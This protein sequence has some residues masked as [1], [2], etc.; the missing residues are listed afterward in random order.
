MSEEF[1]EKLRRYSEGTLSGPELEEME[2]ELAKMEEYQQFLEE[3]LERQEQEDR[4]SDEG[5][6]T[7]K[8]GEPEGDHQEHLSG[9]RRRFTGFGFG[10]KRNRRSPKAVNEKAVIRSGKWRA[11]LS[12]TLTVIS[13]FL[14]LFVLS[15]IVTAVYYDGTGK[16]MK[17]AAVAESAVALSNPNVTLDLN[18]L[19]TG[20]WM[21]MTLDG[22]LQKRVGDNYS[23]YAGDFNMEFKLGMPA[24]SERVWSQD[25][26]PNLYF[27][28][29]D[30]ET[31]SNAESFQGGRRDQEA[32][33]LLEK[34]PEGTVAEAYLSLDR[35]YGTDELLALLEGRNMEPLWFAADGGPDSRDHYGGA[36]TTPVGFPYRPVL[37]E[38]DWTVTSRTEEK[39][40]WFG[41]VTSESRVAEGYEA[42]GDG[43]KRDDNFIR[44][45]KLI[46]DYPRIADRAVP[47]VKW[48]EALRYIGS[49]GVGLYGVVVTGPVKELLTLQ[50]EDWISNLAVGEVRFW[51]WSDRDT[52]H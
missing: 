33:E 48:D 14:V 13:A 11:R 43:D 6:Q 24:Y 46:N 17:Y 9:R 15:S 45:L 5:E 40:G 8:A 1:K 42:Y 49:N 39:R 26:V 10:S 20:A 18:N 3:Q 7:A 36:V 37:L 25:R 4:I 21:N 23:V 16:R 31:L 47:F 44:N 41:S 27:Y 22:K 38:E 2:Q 51:N 32:W 28:Y 19:N 50:E 35:L 52:G 34:L 30:E 29:P 12:N